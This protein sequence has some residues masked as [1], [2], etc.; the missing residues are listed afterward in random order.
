MSAEA[1]R[2]NEANKQFQQEQMRLRLTLAI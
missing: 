1:E 2:L